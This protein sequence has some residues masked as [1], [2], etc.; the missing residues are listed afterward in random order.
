MD[1]LEFRVEI[2]VNPVTEA[3]ADENVQE[4]KID[5]TDGLSKA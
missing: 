1:E 5:K 4:N 2:C 3:R